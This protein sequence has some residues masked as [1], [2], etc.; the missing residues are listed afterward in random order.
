M[1]QQIFYNK[2]ISK[3]ELKS[4]IHLTFQSYS[5][6][7][8]TNLVEKFKKSGFCFA[9]KAGISISIEDL[10]VPPTK[11]ALFLKNNTEI[12]LTHF[13]EKRGNIN[14][15]ERFQKIIG[16][17]HDTSELLKNQLVDFF[18]TV[19]P[20][21]PVYTMTFSGARG[22]LSQ[23]RQLIG[24]RGLMSD[25]NG[26][27]IDL[28]IKSNF[29]EGLTVTDYL[30]SG[31]GAR[32]GI[33]DTALKTADSGYL[34]RRLVDV[35]QHVIIRELDC[36]TK[37]GIRIFYIPRRTK[38]EKL[39]GR[40]LSKPILKKDNSQILINS[41]KILTTNSINRIN[42][43]TDI[44]LRSPLICES[45][46]SLC[47]KC[48]GW[49]LAQGKLVELADAVGIIAAQ[50]IGEPGTQLTMR[51]FHTGGVFTGATAN[52]IRSS[53]EGKVL[54]AETFQTNNIRT[55]YGEIVLEAQNTSHIFI[56]T[57]Q[58]QLQKIPIA[59]GTLIYV[60]N[61]K[62]IK[63]GDLI[64]EVSNPKRQFKPQTKNVTT[65][66]S[67][68]IQFQNLKNS[69]LPSLKSN[70]L[71][72]IATGE[73]YDIKPN[74]LIK[75][76]KTTI[77]KDN[78]LAQTKIITPL[79]G[80]IKTSTNG[81][82]LK[83]GL[84]NGLI[85]FPFQYLYKKNNEILFIFNKNYNFQIASKF[86]RLNFGI[87]KTKKYCVPIPYKFFIS[88]LY[89]N[90]DNN[91]FQIYLIQPKYF[92]NLSLENKKQMF[93]KI[94]K[95][96]KNRDLVIQRLVFPGEIIT[97]SIVSTQLSYFSIIARLETHLIFQIN[98]LAQCGVAKH[99]RRPFS[100]I[101]KNLGVLNKPIVCTT[102]I[103]FNCD[104]WVKENESFIQMSLK[105]FTS[106]QKTGHQLIRKNLSKDKLTQNLFG[107]FLI[108]TFPI[109][110]PSVESQTYDTTK[111]V[112]TYQTAKNQFVDSYSTIATINSIINEKTKIKTIKTLK[113]KT[114]KLL[115]TTVDNYKS[116]PF[117]NNLKLSELKFIVVG[118]EI[119]PNKFANYSGYNASLNKQ[120]PPL[121]ISIRISVPFFISVGARIFKQHGS[122]IYK[123][124]SLCQLVYNRIVSDD[125]VS[126]L[127]R[128]EN[129]FEA[130]GKK[131]FQ[132]LIENPGIIK[133]NKKTLVVFEKRGKKCY[134]ECFDISLKKGEFVLVGQP[135][136]INLRHPHSV[137]STYFKYYCSFYT[138]EYSAMLSVT[139]IQ[140]L[141]LNL[142]QDVYKSQGINIADKH[143]EIIIRQIT[144]KVQILDFNI[145]TFFM[146]PEYMEV[147]Q[148]NYINTALKTVK[149]PLIGYQ[150][151]LLGITKVSLMTES[152]ISAASFQ[153]TTRVLAQS[154]VEGRVEWLRGLKENVILGR[155]IPAGT[156][157]KSFSTP[158]LLNN[159]LTN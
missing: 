147:N 128:V 67:G 45:S 98:P 32:K 100:R 36:K 64:A 113:H 61:N 49:S 2:V 24:M 44:V 39:L 145:D 121:T 112:I 8:A 130:R 34:T 74:M 3:K 5:I 119:G 37:N 66:V 84:V 68:E 102:Q 150:P 53:F 56:L 132:S 42:F 35:A 76:P 87:R 78:S 1:G 134:N 52:Q 29:R 116:Y 107:Y 10:K 105:F 109:N 28:P 55:M 51:T 93:F 117:Q 114:T 149:A 58:S 43:S 41:D 143:I 17:W 148:V 129:L 159:R 9:T 96:E 60:R 12:K 88:K 83:I 26:Q 151:T 92:N 138:A 144:S 13:Y 135:I 46:H 125:I 111:T 80:L 77:I 86:N 31:Y 95:N 14:E 16:M 153:E 154:A 38:F 120:T 108:Y 157:F 127:P 70:G 155:L 54:F 20:L 4:I 122:L 22:N 69:H 63:K 15:V 30:I 131:T 115:M 156:G 19:D 146:P 73:V 91:N 40:V 47:Q 65:N 126:G 152:F 124:E 50:S 11:K 141:L 104:T 72:W 123:G 103:K 110:L 118:D 59:I 89:K 62:F 6:G 18:K 99:F 21:N 139:N 142:V 97:S 81:F 85:T 106:S 71:I 23:V 90:I 140:I 75:I 82:H 7:K 33:V 27:I 48:Y 133:D 101:P 158:A 25:P 79:K 137:L 136:D 57:N 94:V